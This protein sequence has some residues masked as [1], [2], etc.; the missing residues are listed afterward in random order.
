MSVNELLSDALERIAE[1][2]NEVSALSEALDFERGYSKQGWI[3]VEDRLPD[4]L[5]EVLSFAYHNGIAHS[6]YRSKCFKKVNVVWD[7]QK[8]THWMP[9]PKPPKEQGE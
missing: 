4:E 8:V 6:I 1:L 7:H 9:L 5:Q 2:E 3:S